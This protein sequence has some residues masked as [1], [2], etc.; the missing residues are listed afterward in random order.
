MTTD[1]PKGTRV[2]T[3]YGVNGE[4]FNGPSP[5]GDYIITDADGE[6]HVVSRDR[7]M[8]EDSLAA[9]ISRLWHQAANDNRTNPISV[10]A[11]LEYIAERLP[12]HYEMQL[13]FIPEPEPEDEDDEY[14]S[15][16]DWSAE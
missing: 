16:Y 2:L 12:E 11:H 1:L 9:I 13:K 10:P 8:V 6:Y 7:I 4:I 15:G 5:L 14:N 3:D